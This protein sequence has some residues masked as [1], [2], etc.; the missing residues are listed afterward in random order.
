[1]SVAS[2]P[3]Y[4]CGRAVPDGCGEP[5]RACL[6]VLPGG[7]RHW[8]WVEVCPACARKSAR[9]R[10]LALLLVSVM[11]ALLTSAVAYPLLP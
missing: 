8:A 2:E 10:R 6:G 3:C 9:Q 7:G 11:V 1:M 4:E 5:A